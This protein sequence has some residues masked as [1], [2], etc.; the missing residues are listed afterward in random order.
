MLSVRLLWFRTERLRNVNSCLHDYLSPHLP[1]MKGIHIFCCSTNKQIQAP[2]IESSGICIVTDGEV[3]AGR[4]AVLGF[5]IRINDENRIAL[6]WWCS[7][8][9]RCPSSAVHVLD[10]FK[11]LS[12]HAAPLSTDSP[13]PVTSDVLELIYLSCFIVHEYLRH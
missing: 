7:T 11:L 6:L 13:L 8:L 2:C 10:R 12:W 5:D 4:N 9:A 1:K 3:E